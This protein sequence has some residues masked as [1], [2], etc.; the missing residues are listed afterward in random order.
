MI[1]RSQAIT[2]SGETCGCPYETRMPWA[3]CS[4]AMPR[5]ARSRRAAG[6][7]KGGVVVGE[8]SLGLGEGR[9]TGHKLGARGCGDYG[10]FG[11]DHGL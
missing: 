4:G 7:L 8:G 9:R 6:A 5:A 10:Q 11:Q 2:W 1:P 3:T